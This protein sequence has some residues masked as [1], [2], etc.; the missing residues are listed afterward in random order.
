MARWMVDVEDTR[1]N[2]GL[3]VHRGADIPGYEVS[4]TEFPGWF[5]SA[6]D[7]SHNFGLCR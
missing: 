5:G 4:G 7:K 6:V 1:A 2:L 3:Q